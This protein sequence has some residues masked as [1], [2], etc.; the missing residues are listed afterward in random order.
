MFV[1]L[2]ALL[3]LPVVGMGQTIKSLAISPNPAAVGGVATGTVTLSKVAPSGGL[4]INLRSSVAATASVPSSLT[5]EAGA[6]NA[7]F[8]V[9]IHKVALTARTTITGTDP[10]KKS[11]HSVLVVNPPPIRL[12]NLAVTPAAIELPATAKGTVTLSADATGN[13]FVVNL[14]SD[15]QFVSLP[16]SVSVKAG[17]KT[18]TFTI[19]GS[20]I[21]K[22]TSATIKGID[23]N[24]Y[25]A[26]AKLMVQVP[27]VRVA[28]LTLTP[29]QVGAGVA[30]SGVVTLTSAAP[31]G[32]FDVDLSSDQ[33]F[34][35]VPAKV[36]VKAGAKTGTFAITTD[37]SSNG[38]TANLMAMDAAGYMAM[39]SLSVTVSTVRISTITIAPTSVTAPAA[40][41]G[42]IKLSGPAPAAGLA[43]T[44]SSAQTFVNVPTVVTVNSGATT[45]T[46]NIATTSPSATTTAT[47]KGVDPNGISATATLTVS[48]QSNL[49]SIQMTSGFQ[50][51]PQTLTVTAGTTVVWTNVSGMPHTVTPDLSNPSM[52]S[53]T[54]VAGQSFVWTLPANA[55][56]GTKFFYH[57]LFHGAAGDGTTMGQGMAGVVIVK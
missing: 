22:N 57:C 47:I 30:S 1:A 50:Y 25:S 51:S 28:S 35:T 6:A 52:T 29:K 37:A 15:E 23:A 21:A 12:I 39:A 44:L 34:V 17:A 16:A 18:A 36:T 20:S 19:S 40:A 9:T 48:P 8:T 42:T 7:T 10:S 11:A 5:I 24:T 4:K 26:T 46:F 31:K 14:S 13:G 43:I 54:I 3:A 53:G 32:G 41:T 27:A 56:S 55:K 33:Q 38:G 45:A 49:A 2:L